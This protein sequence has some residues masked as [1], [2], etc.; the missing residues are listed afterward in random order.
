M[1]STNPVL[2]PFPK[3]YTFRSLK[4]LEGNI[5]EGLDS[6]FYSSRVGPQLLRAI[7]YSSFGLCYELIVSIISLLVLWI[8]YFCMTYTWSCWIGIEG[9]VTFLYEGSMYTR[10]KYILC[11][12]RGLCK[13]Q[14]R[15]NNVLNFS[16]FFNLWVWLHENKR[17]VLVL[18]KDDDSGYF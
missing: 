3:H 16:V 7:P 18:K 2:F 11:V 14:S 4:S 15:E 12:C 9:Y 5:V 10:Y 17:L 13:P 1:W 8:L 6:S